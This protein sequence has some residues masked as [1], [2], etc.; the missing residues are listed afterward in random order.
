MD[1]HENFYVFGLCQRAE[2]VGLLL[3]RFR[4]AEIL[5]TL[6]DDT[7]AERVFLRGVE[8]SLRDGD[9]ADRRGGADNAVVGVVIR[10]AVDFAR[11]KRLCDDGNHD[12]VVVADGEDD[13]WRLQDFLWKFL[14]LRL[15]RGRLL[16]VAEADEADEETNGVFHGAVL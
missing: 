11:K 10:L 6:R 1:Y 7:A 16:C 9:A 3:E 12:L 4:P 13:G 14:G 2:F 8:F 15:L 5:A